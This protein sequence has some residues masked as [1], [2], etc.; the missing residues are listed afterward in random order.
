MGNE[1]GRANGATLRAA[2]QE[3]GMA[4]SGPNCMAN[5]IATT[6][7]VTMPDDRWMQLGKGPVAVLGQQVGEQQTG[8]A[9]SDDGD[10]GTHAGIV[11]ARQRPEK[12]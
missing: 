7:M 5:I 4:V 6:P 3:T 2:I 12:R 9:R 10:L 11:L 8:W 1:E